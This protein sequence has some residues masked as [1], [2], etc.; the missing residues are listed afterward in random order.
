MSLKKKNSIMKIVLYKHLVLFVLL[1]LPV[2]QL[3]G[4]SVEKRSVGSFHGIKASNSVTVYLEKGNSP[5]VTVEVEGMDLSDVITRVDG[6][7]LKIE[8]DRGNFRNID[9]KVRVTFTTLDMIAASSASGIYSEDVIKASRLAIMASSAA[10]VDISV[11]AGELKI[12]VSSAADVEISGKTQSVSIDVQ[13]AGEVDAYDLIAQV[14]NVNASSAG[15][16]KV[17]VE[18]DI[19]ALA[20]SGGSIKYKGNPQKSST[21][22][23]SGGSVRK[24][25]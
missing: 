23:R 6:G 9:V 7:I 2:L 25:N 4:Q 11:D 13:S 24:V 18:Q 21:D 12:D 8:L 22:S 5:S 20:S 1:T 19:R 10:S 14:V 3:F 15:D 17:F 16:A